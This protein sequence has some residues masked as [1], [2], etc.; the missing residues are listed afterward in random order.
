MARRPLVVGNWKMHKT[1]REGAAFAEELLALGLPDGVD[2]ALAPAFP[3]LESVGRVLAG[4]SVALAAQDVFAEPAGAYTGEV[5]AAM[6][7]DL[8]VSLVLVGHSERRR[9]RGEAE[10]ELAEKMRRLAER[11]LT[12]LYCVGETLEEREAGRTLEAL[13]R[14]MEAFEAFG[15][16]P[17]SLV[18]A[19]E[20]VWAIGTGRAATP[21][22]AAE[23]HA[24]IRRLLAERFGR[25]AAADTRLLYGGSVTRGNAAALFAEEEIDGALVGGAALEPG[26]LLEIARA[27]ARSAGRD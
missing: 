24:D 22:L 7:A 15:E 6:L 12:P 2:V 19:Y 23:A 9:G 25:D 27:A 3:A 21:A 4:T 14:Q 5:S 16:P 17:G 11:G 20:P 10:P 13:A 18:V 26:S 8:E 1:S